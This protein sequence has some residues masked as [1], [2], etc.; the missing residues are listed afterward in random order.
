MCVAARRA[1]GTAAALIGNERILIHL[2]AGQHFDIARDGMRR[3]AAAPARGF[4]LRPFLAE[5]RARLLLVQ[6][7]VAVG[8]FGIV[9][10]VIL[11]R[12]AGSLDIED[13]NLIDCVGRVADERRGEQ[14]EEDERRRGKDAQ[15]RRLPAARTP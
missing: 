7:A 13:R 6:H 1:D 15:G 14:T 5:L 10:A 2:Q 8:L 12:A 11:R 3:D 4:E 9:H